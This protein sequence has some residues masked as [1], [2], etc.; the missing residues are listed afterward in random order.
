[1]ASGAWHPTPSLQKLKRLN[2]Q[3]WQFSISYSSLTPWL[4]FYF[5]F[6]IEMFNLKFST[7][8]LSQKNKILLFRMTFLGAGP[9]W[10]GTILVKSQLKIKCLH[11]LIYSLNQKI[12]NMKH[13]HAQTTENREHVLFFEILR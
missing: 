3:W 12:S 13:V 6:V 5:Y 10:I 1:M 8:L 9:F 7:T 2:F 4:F 11:H